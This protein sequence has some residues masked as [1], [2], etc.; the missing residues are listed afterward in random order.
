MFSQFRPDVAVA[1]GANGITTAVL[2]LGCGDRSLP[3]LHYWFSD[4]VALLSAYIYWASIGYDS[5]AY[6]VLSSRDTWTHTYGAIA[7]LEEGDI[8]AATPVHGITPA[9]CPEIP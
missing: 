1:T 8:S 4:A 7:P 9:R 2:H 6:T 3:E 5:M